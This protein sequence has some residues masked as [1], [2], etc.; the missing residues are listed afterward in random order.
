MYP[1]YLLRNK[2]FEK[3]YDLSTQDINPIHESKIVLYNDFI[4]SIKEKMN[5][6]SYLILNEC[7][8]IK[9]ENWV[10]N[11]HHNF[12]KIFTWSPKLVDDK[13][14]IRI[15]WPNLID[16][17]S[18][19]KPKS[20]LCCMISA[21]KKNNHPNSL[22]SKRLDIIKWFEKNYPN[23]FVLYGIG[24]DKYIPKNTFISKLLRKSKFD[25]VFASKRPSFRGQVEKKFDVLNKH[26]FS[27]SLENAHSIPGYITEKI[28][29]SFIALC[30]PIYLGAPDITD[31]I[32]A[33]TFIDLRNYNTHEEL[34][35]YLK[36]M[37]KDEY[38]GY[39]QNIH[40]YLTSSEIYKFTSKA[41]VD[42]IIEYTIN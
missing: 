29:D 21:N 13:K 18:R 2:F 28:F 15:F 11:K 22:Y 32:P 24:W 37:S 26:K 17:K 31:H 5:D 38:D 19:E 42:T 27:I 36:N 30:V 34:Y 25:E 4:P 16:I 35:D 20:N 8:I 14:Y 12:K 33:N 39:L 1:N 41:F 7:E 40:S 10:L 9:P 3:G 23:E 6:N